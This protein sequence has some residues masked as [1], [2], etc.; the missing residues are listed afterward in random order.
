VIGSAA[1][2]YDSSLVLKGYKRYGIC[3][4]ADMPYA[5]TF[6]P[7]NW[8]S[9]QATNRASIIRSYGLR[10]HWVKTN[11]GKVGVS[12]KEIEQIKATLQLGWPVC[13]GS[14]HSVLFVGYKDDPSLDNGGGFFFRDSGGGKKEIMTYSEA[15][16]R[17]CDLLWF[18]AEAS[19]SK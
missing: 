7:Q 19:E 9:P 13:A 12:E 5:R 10:A 4:E 3:T 15:K 14:Y 11:D 2:K 1:R 17:L 6:M 8:P 16:A 18:E